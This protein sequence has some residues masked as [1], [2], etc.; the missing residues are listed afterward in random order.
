MSDETD[1]DITGLLAR[2]RAGD[3]DAENSLM[4]AVYP[5]LRELARLRLRRAGGDPTLSATELVNEAYSRLARG[6]AVDYQNRAHFFAVAAR[7]IRNFVVD[8]LRARG[9]EK[10]GGG[11]PFVELDSADELRTEDLIDLR[12]DWLAVHEALDRLENID[13]GCARIV[14]LKFFSGLTTEEIA[15]VSGVS[16]ATVVRNWRFAKAWLLDQLRPSGER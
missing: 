14:E 1:I 7:A 12:T 3:R 5:L 16:R 2:W 15:H 8:Y 6:E 10:R 11:L 4:N 13:Q 9:S